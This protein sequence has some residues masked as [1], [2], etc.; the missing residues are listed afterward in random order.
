MVFTRRSVVACLPFA[1]ACQAT[2]RSPR[3]Y[4]APGGRGNGS[5]WG[6]PAS[7]LD[8][9]N[10][11]GRVSPGGEI[12]VAADAGSY[13]LRDEIQIAS[14]GSRYG[15]ISIRGVNRTSG[16]PQ[17]ATLLG[18]PEQEGFR[19]LRG[20]N[21]LRFS[22][23]EFLNFGNGCFRVGAP[24]NDLTIEDCRFEQ[25]YRFLENTVSGA[26]TDASLTR[27]YVRRCSGR[28]VLRSFSRVR[29]SS[30]DGVFENC[31]ARGTPREGLDFP[32]GGV[33]EDQAGRI[34]YR[35]CIMENFQQLNAGDYWNGDGFSDEPENFEVRYERCEARGSTDGGFDCKSRDVVL[36][37]CISEDN[38]R[39]FR[40]WSQRATLS[41]CVSR[42]PHWRGAGVESADSCHVWVGGEQVPIIVNMSNF[43][44]Q[45]S[46][47]IPIFSF[48]NESV[49]VRLQGLTVRS[50]QTNWGDGA[51]RRVAGAVTTVM[52][53][54][55]P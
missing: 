18:R 29:Y 25:V 13:D 31:S 24:V 19:L 40:I 53:Q 2:A 49:R 4:V 12:L 7:L 10:L 34:T 5:S 16:A 33:L 1:I 15:S 55:V 54:I 50:P 43:T 6:D 23:F 38:K 39:N 37:H 20:A 36:D 27:F 28:G 48:E 35:S 32:A 11:I 30:R 26:E 47:S 52:P 42:S 17:L 45:D 3:L 9:N 22:H 51:V 41:S 14:G 21:D 46:D 44:V 8:L